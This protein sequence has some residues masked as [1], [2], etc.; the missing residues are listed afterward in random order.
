MSQAK[1]RILV[2]DDNLTF[3]ELAALALADEFEVFSAEN[4]AEGME[5][6]R[7][8]APDAILLDVMMPKVSGVE[9][10]REL[11]S[12]PETSRIPVVILSGSKLDPSTKSMIEREANVRAYL[13]K[14]CPAAQLRH[15]I[16]R[17]LGKA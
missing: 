8:Q 14:P 13:K 3:R 7:K 1:K 15:Q 10:L 17:A 4:G 16:H 11:Q 12:D 9:M 2:V 6:V 5:L